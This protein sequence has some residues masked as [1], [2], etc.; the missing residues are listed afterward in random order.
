VPP[1][2]GECGPR[3]GLADAAGVRNSGDAPGTRKIDLPRG[4]PRL[5]CLESANMSEFIGRDR[6]NPQPSRPDDQLSSL[7]PGHIDADDD[8]VM[9]FR[10]DKSKSRLTEFPPAVSD[11][12]MPTDVDESASMAAPAVDTTAVHWEP[13]ADGHG[14][15]TIVIRYG[16]MGQLGEFTHDLPKTPLPGSKLVVRTERGVELGDV[17]VTVSD[18][19]SWRCI[20]SSRMSEYIKSNGPEYPF[21]RGGRV[22]R[23]ANQ[24]DL[25]DFRHLEKSAHEERA[26][27]RQQI[28]ELNLAMKLVTVEHLLG[29]E[30]IIFYFA[31]ETRVDFRELVRRLAGQFRTR[32]EMRQVGA[33]D[34]A[35]LVADFERCGQRCCCQ[36]YIK[37]LKP[38]SMRMA[39]TQKATLDPTKI[40]GR[41]SRLMCCLRYE[42]Q[43]YEEMRKLLPR[44]NIW[45]RT[46]KLVGRVIDS[47]IIT[48]LVRLA[49]PDNTLVVVANEEILERDVPAPPI[50]P[51]HEPRES[52]RDERPTQLLRDSAA[53]NTPSA[54]QADNADNATKANQP[55]D[56]MPA[57]GLSEASAMPEMP[58]GE[59]ASEGAN[60]G[61][62]GYEDTRDADGSTEQ[63]P[64]QPAGGNQGQRP[65]DRNRRGNRQRQ[66]QRQGPGRGQNQRQSQGQG[67]PQGQPQSP[68]QE[69][70][71]NQGQGQAP[72]QE[73]GR[74]KR[75]RRRRRSG[76]PNAGPAGNP[77]SGG[78]SPSGDNSSGGPSAS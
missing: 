11:S 58:L 65:A 25:I 57:A 4:P 2:A 46:E 7:P 10:Q 27:C 61:Q 36:Q 12:F 39:K 13:P 18:E 43:G 42:D 22:L 53:N 54:G 52:H 17:M 64:A 66:G 20:V 35:R 60:A 62:A 45:V 49:L 9:G 50:H 5:L 48:Q 78:P 51:V 31:A 23:T 55:A 8:D 16:I 24:Q 30:R 77:P 70:N 3:P 71:Q 28:R 33:R 34:E 73:P 68:G 21:T 14:N 19:P 38:V 67:Q 63:A 37:D 56:N 75:R 29:G 15:T 47:Q 32:I 72:G 26:F 76:G 69:Q 40:S 41:C 74:R 44:K 6:A 59:S 1:A